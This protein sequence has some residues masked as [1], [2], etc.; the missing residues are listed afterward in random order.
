MASSSAFSTGTFNPPDSII[1]ACTSVSFCMAAAGMYEGDPAQPTAHTQ[2]LLDLMMV[3]PSGPSIMIGA[4]P[5]EDFEWVLS[6]WCWPSAGDP[7]VPE[8]PSFGER[9]MARMA[10][11]YAKMHNKVGQP[12]VQ[13]AQSSNAPSMDES[14]GQAVLDLAHQV[15]NLAAA[16]VKPQESN[17]PLKETVSQ[18]SDATARRL[19]TDEIIKCYDRWRKIFGSKKRPALDE[20]PS[21]D[22]LSSLAHLLAAGVEGNIYVDFAVWGPQQQRSIKRQKLVGQVLNSRGEFTTVE[23]YGPA[24][25]GM[26][27]ACWAV[28]SNALLLLGAVD[29]GNLVDYGKFMDDIIAR[30]GERAY[31]LMYQADVRTRN[32]QMPRLLRDELEKHNSLTNVPADYH[33]D[34]A[35]PWDCVFRTIVDESM[36]AKWWLRQLERP[37]MMMVCSSTTI[38][39]VLGGDAPIGHTVPHDSPPGVDAHH[40]TIMPDISGAGAVSHG[41]WAVPGAKASAKPKAAPGREHRMDPTGQYYTHSRRGVKLC[42]AF[43]GLG[44]GAT[45]SNEMCPNGNGLHLCCRCLQPHSISQCP[46]SAASVPGWAARQAAK[47][48]GKGKGKGKG[49]SGKGKGQKPQRQGPYGQN[50]TPF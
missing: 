27:K 40:I 47:G 26:W 30:F 31:P 17:I 34:P 14:V 22:Q 41:A 15:Q 8:Y 23:I 43:N 3:H 18:V 4:G 50:W 35:R 19:T 16:Q 48:Q 42:E 10:R 9:Q 46:S 49:K 24:T 21:V 37:A 12:Q 45:L 33:F 2:V 11:H 25:Y 39:Q 44:C 1:E 6:T 36:Q 7:Q 29:L 5:D 13:P 28:Y 32:E 38:G 20:D